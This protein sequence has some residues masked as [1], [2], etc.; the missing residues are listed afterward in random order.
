MPG[1]GTV[2]PVAASGVTANSSTKV[3]HTVAAESNT[4]ADSVGKSVGMV[5][6]QRVIMRRVCRW[7]GANLD[8]RMLCTS[9][10]EG[11]LHDLQSHMRDLESVMQLIGR[12]F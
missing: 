2:C 3:G 8:L 6:L 7:P 1:S 10:G 11:F 4:G 12:V 9:G 5:M